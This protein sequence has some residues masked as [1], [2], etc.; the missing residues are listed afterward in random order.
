MIVSSCSVKEKTVESVQQADEISVTKAKADSC[1]KA[2]DYQNAVKLLSQVI[3]LGDSLSGEVYYKRGYALMQLS[4]HLSSSLDLQKAVSLKYRE[5]DS[6]YLLGLNE[7]VVPNDSTA[8]IYFEK[9]LTI[10]PND[11][12]VQSALEAC[13]KRVISLDI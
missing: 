9:S 4:E 10:N 1:Y 11:K 12:Q 2:R 8:I 13:K 6:Y 7:I 3:E 5:A